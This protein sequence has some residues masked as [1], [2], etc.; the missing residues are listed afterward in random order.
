MISFIYSWSRLTYLQ[1][2]EASASKPVLCSPVIANVNT[3]SYTDP[4]REEALL[5]AANLLDDKQSENVRYKLF[6][7]IMSNQEFNVRNVD[8]KEALSTKSA[9][10]PNRRRIL[11]LASYL[12]FVVKIPHSIAVEIVE[13]SQCGTACDFGVLFTA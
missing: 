12:E 9:I 5:F 11:L 1:A 6:D 10:S 13:F 8:L 7:Y 2:D 4:Q 3:D